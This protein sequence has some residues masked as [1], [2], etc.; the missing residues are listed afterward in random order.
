M[1]QVRNKTAD[2]QFMEVMTCPQGCISGGGQ[3]KLYLET[4]KKEAFR[5]RKQ[6]LY[7]EDALQTVHAS[8]QNPAIEKIYKDFLGKPLGHKSH[9]LLHTKYGE[10]TKNKIL[11][12]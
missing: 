2:F 1:Q 10:H 5:K 8:H 4:E 3:P 7:E 9:T 6:G 11:E 12:G